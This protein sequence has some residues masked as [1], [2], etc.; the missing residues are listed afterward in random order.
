MVNVHA[1]LLVFFDGRRPGR[2]AAFFFS[3]FDS[4]YRKTRGCRSLGSL[5]NA[6]CGP[7]AQALR[8]LM[9]LLLSSLI[10]FFTFVHGDPTHFRG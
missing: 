3:S 5:S 1:S 7:T 9:S 8:I 6:C 10:S 4:M 2:F